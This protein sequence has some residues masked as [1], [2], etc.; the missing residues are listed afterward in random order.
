MFSQMLYSTLN[1]NRMWRCAAWTPI[2]VSILGVE[3]PAKIFGQPL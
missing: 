2:V 1:D 3:P